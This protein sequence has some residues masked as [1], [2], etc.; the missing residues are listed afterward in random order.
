MPSR[1]GRVRGLVAE[2]RVGM[3]ALLRFVRGR[4]E[5]DGAA[6]V[7]CS[8]PSSIGTFFASRLCTIADNDLLAAP[9]RS[10]KTCFLSSASPSTTVPA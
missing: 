8:S 2:W 3:A 9:H 7:V 6:V 10:L 1:S 4:P 5:R